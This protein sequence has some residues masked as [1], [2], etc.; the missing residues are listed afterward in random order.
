MSSLSIAAAGVLC[1][2]EPGG[3]KGEKRGK[4]RER[5]T[6]ADVCKRGDADRPLLPPPSEEERREG[7]SEKVRVRER[8]AMQ[9]G[10]AGRERG[11]GDGGSL[12]QRQNGLLLSLATF[13]YP[14]SAG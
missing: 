3:S 13:I 14:D 6:T 4:E 9:R 8:S 5:A 11:K 12:A 7:T 1:A 10:R 2:G